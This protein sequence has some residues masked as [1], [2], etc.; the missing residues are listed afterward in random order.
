MARFYVSLSLLCYLLALCFDAVELSGGLHLPSLQVLL[1]GPWGI[2]FGLFGW[3]AN[4]LFGLALLV[5]RRWRWFSLVLGLLALYLAIGSHAIER[6][7]ENQSYNFHDVLHFEAGYYL[8]ASAIAV[9]CAGQAWW[10]SVGRKA[11]VPR[12]SL[13]EGGL[14]LL[15]LVVVMLG[16]RDDSLRFD[17]ERAFDWPSDGQMRP[18]VRGES[19]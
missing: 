3:F 17:L 1:Q 14:A 12:W 2:A 5:R 13:V 9:F 6:L 11:E 18:P 10:C 15:L 16:L 19:I 7:P 4:P 8:W